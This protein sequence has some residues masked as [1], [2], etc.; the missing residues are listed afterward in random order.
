MP[1]IKPPDFEEMMKM[2]DVIRLLNNEVQALKV[3]ID[4]EEAEIVKKVSRD[5]SYSPDGKYLST[6]FINSTYKVTGIDGEL[7]PKRKKLGRAVA[8]LDKA[9]KMFEVMKMQFEAW[10][11]DQA[12]NRRMA[13]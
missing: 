11:T 4:V 7:I 12:N 1:E 9:Y 13:I 8:E 3:E 5:K 2:L 10:R 6:T